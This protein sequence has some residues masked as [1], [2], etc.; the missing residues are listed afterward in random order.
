MKQI[1][2]DLIQF[3][4]EGRF[5]VIIQGCNCFNV[6]GSG[7]A[8][9]I[10]ENF[11]EAYAADLSTAKGDIS[12]LGTYSKAITGELIILN[13]YTQNRYGRDS[14]VVYADYKAIAQVF[15]SIAKDFPN[16]RIGYPKIGAGFANGNWEIIRDIIDLYLDGLDH[17]LVVF[18]Q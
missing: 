11:P 4:K 13:A 18:E 16:K 6:M 15:K 7:V 9:G 5:D 8:K 1:T 12:K 17:T 10:K 14:S 2:G 3:A